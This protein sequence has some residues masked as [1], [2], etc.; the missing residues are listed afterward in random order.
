MSENK[1]KKT[2][3]DQVKDWEKI[4]KQRLLLKNIQK[5]KELCADVVEAKEEVNIILEKLAISKE[6]SK[7]LIDFLNENED[8]KM[9]K[10]KRKKIEEDVEKELKQEKNKVIEELE[11]SLRKN[12]YGFATTS[13]NSGIIQAYNC[14]TTSAPNYLGN[15]C[16]SSNTSGN[17]VNLSDGKTDLVLKI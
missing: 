5:L 14:H 6:D 8:V 9:N 13:Y 3:L 15:I 4:K 1:D 17:A 11:E 2:I 16:M 12:P 7:A 10:E